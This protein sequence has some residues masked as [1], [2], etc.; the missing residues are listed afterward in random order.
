M[1]IVALRLALFGV[2][3]LGSAARAFADAPAEQSWSAEQREVWET[4]IAW[5]RAFE[6]ND[7]G[8][9]F[10]F[11]HPAITV[12][13]PGNPYRISGVEADRREFEFSLS[14]GATRVGYFQEIDPK[15]SVYGSTAVVTYYSRGYYGAE[16]GATQYYKETDVLVKQG[17]AWKIVHI[18][19]SSSSP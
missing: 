18:H 6:R 19:V 4:V 3:I 10:E 11:I 9:Y 17:S 5:N 8:A 2:V 13:T 7:P 12:I 15:V 16:K 14:K 1:R